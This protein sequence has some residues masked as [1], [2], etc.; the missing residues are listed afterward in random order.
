M[1]RGTGG[2]GC[3]R[4]AQTRG[5]SGPAKDEAYYLH[6][7]CAFLADAIKRAHGFPLA[8][9]MLGDEEGEEGV[10]VFNRIGEAEIV[11][12]K[13]RRA[14]TE[15]VAEYAPPGEAWE[16]DNLP[17]DY[18]EGEIETADMEAADAFLA[19]LGLAPPARTETPI[20][21]LNPTGGLFVEY[22]P[23][24]RA[25]APLAGA[26]T[27]LDKTMEVDSDT[28][29]TIYRGAPAH[30]REITP[31]D[32]VTTNPQL[33]RDYGMHVIEKQVPASHVLD[34]S[35]EPLGEEYIYRPPNPPAEEPYVAPTINDLA[36]LPTTYEP[37][38]GDG[39]WLMGGGCVHLAL[40]LK[41]VFPEGKIA[42]GWYDDHGRR[43]ISHAVF[44]NPQ[45]GM[46]WDGCGSWKSWEVAISGHSGETERE[47][48]ADSG[49]IAAQMNIPWNPEAPWEDDRLMEAWT[50]AEKHFLPAW[51]AR[52]LAEY[53]DDED[54]L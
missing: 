4:Q 13:G 54:D 40:A 51:H 8:M 19:T 34:D 15:M 18:S 37:L 36:V 1:A 25:S 44:Y 12:A 50:F 14:L 21:S 42:V 23:T 24:V 30:Q 29:V 49:A 9:L 22:D 27:T 33:A 46:A 43:A 6:G 16:I 11:D 52:T 38:D 28:P 48:D 20:D 3:D 26:L 10:H 53:G 47:E 7:G 39:E 32:F 5:A 2:E 41:E 31:G 17:D 35:A 45:T